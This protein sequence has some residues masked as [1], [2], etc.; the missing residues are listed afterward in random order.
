MELD[1]FCRR[2][3]RQWDRKATVR[4]RPRTRVDAGH[5][6]GDVFPAVL[7]PLVGHPAIVARGPAVRHELL[8]RSAYRW[9]QEIASLEIEIVT[10]LCGRLATQGAG[11]PLPDS[12]RRV[13]LTV[14]TDEAYH[15]YAARAFIDDLERATGIAADRE[16]A[17]RPGLASALDRLRESLPEA[18]RR[19]GETLGLC[20][21]EHFVTESLFGLSRDS[22]AD[23]PFHVAIREHLIDE[24]RH[25]SYFQRLLTHLWAHYDEPRRRAL[26][27]A[28]PGF[29]DAFLLGGT[30][31]DDSRQLLGRIGVSESEA[32]A[33]LAEIQQG[34]EGRGGG[35]S[36]LPQAR[37][38]LALAASSGLLDHAPTRSAL[39]TAG[40]LA[41]PQ[42]AEV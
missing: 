39:T 11:C 33:I 8:V 42:P 14:A 38:C 7:Q 26:G 25:Q 2:Y 30:L 23:N 17:P 9:Q 21:A 40:W 20:F 1:D 19:E 6:D 27:S 5:I 24:A 35:K 29:L 15:A 34:F 18:L 10:D 22:E 4:G 3:L 41:A 36:A 31:L 28:L 37:H 13:A 12:A 16:S 32:D